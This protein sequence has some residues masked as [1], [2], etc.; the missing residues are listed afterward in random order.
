MVLK[1]LV[2]GSTA[3]TTPFAILDSSNSFDLATAY[4]FLRQTPRTT[5]F[6]EGFVTILC[7]RASAKDLI[8][9]TQHVYQDMVVPQHVLS[10]VAAVLAFAQGNP[11]SKQLC[12]PPFKVPTHI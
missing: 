6:A 12:L 9:A 5:N 4:S 3:Q 11:T 1:G 2:I 7:K 8:P 10:N